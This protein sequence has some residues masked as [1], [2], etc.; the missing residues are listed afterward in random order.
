MITLSIVLISLSTNAAASTMQSSPILKLL[1]NDGG[2]SSNDVGLFYLKPALAFQTNLLPLGNNNNYFYQHYYPS[3]TTTMANQLIGGW[4]G[5][6]LS[7]AAPLLTSKLGTTTN[8][9]FSVSPGNVASDPYCNNQYLQYDLNQI[10]RMNLFSQCLPIIQLRNFI[11][12]INNNFGLA[13]Y[14]NSVIGT[15]ALPQLPGQEQQQQSNQALDHS[16]G[17]NIPCINNQC[18]TSSSSVTAGEPSAS[19]VSQQTTCSNNVCQTTTCINNQCQTS[20]G[21]TGGGGQM[22]DEFLP[23]NQLNKM[24]LDINR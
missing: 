23:Y 17:S 5:R 21:A 8:P 3:T 20:F 13:S 12:N 11:S 9:L 14:C 2:S 6:C 24:D 15:T 19:A 1:A 16:S 4:M 22:T 7:A 18:Q 10:N